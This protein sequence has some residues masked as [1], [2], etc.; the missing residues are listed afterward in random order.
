[1]FWIHFS[2]QNADTY[3]KLGAKAV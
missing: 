2:F 1:M 3:L